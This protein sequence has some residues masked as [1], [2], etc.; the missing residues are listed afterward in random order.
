MIGM[1]MF[2]TALLFLLIGVPVAF[3]FGGVAILFALL[4]PWDV[5]LQVFEL[6]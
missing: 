6:L 4:F 3:A 5:G 1:L 2:V